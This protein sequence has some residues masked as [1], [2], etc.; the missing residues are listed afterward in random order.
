MQVISVDS[1][2]TYL[3]YTYIMILSRLRKGIPLNIL[4][5]MTGNVV[6]ALESPVASFREQSADMQVVPHKYKHK[7]RGFCFQ[8]ETFI[9]QLMA[10]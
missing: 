5:I 3:F 7:Y 1:Q 6:Q 4:G 2:R 8:I 9:R 10:F